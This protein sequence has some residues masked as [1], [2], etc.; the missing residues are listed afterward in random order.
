MNILATLLILV[1]H[2]D[3][4]YENDALSRYAIACDLIYEQTSDKD[5]LKASEKCLNL[6]IL[7]MH[8]FGWSEKAPYDSYQDGT[9]NTLETTYTYQTTIAGFAFLRHYKI[10]GNPKYLM[11]CEKI[12]DHLLNQ[13]GYWKAPGKLAMWYS[14]SEYDRKYRVH[15]VNWYTA[16]YLSQLNYNEY[17]AYIDDILSYELSTR[18]GYNWYYCEDLPE[19]GV[20]DM[21]HWAM[22]GNAVREIYEVTQDDRLLFYKDMQ[23][24]YRNTFVKQT[25][26]NNYWRTDL[27]Y[28]EA[29]RFLQ[30]KSLFDL[31]EFKSFKDQVCLAWYCYVYAEL[32]N[33]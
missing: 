11:I 26:L 22:I 14:S 3:S 33:K 32:L 9:I 30:D 28:A 20:N 13:I 19:R 21:F 7:K 18:R 12:A 8:D 23:K 16:S 10:T 15:N 27:A 17:K 6:L 5:Y 2:A 1:S 29:V 31:Y 4:A 24:A 25:F